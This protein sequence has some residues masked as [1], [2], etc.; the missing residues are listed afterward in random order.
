MWQ[1][2]I[3]FWVLAIFKLIPMGDV[4][5]MLGTYSQNI[6]VRMLPPSASLEI[7]SALICG[8]KL[9]G[10]NY[11]ILKTLNLIHVIMASG[12]VLFWL[13]RALK[14]FANIYRKLLLLG[15]YFFSG[16]HPSI[17]RCLI[18]QSLFKNSKSLSVS[19]SLLCSGIAAWLLMDH[20]YILILSWACAILF[21]WA[22]ML[23]QNLFIKALF[24]YIGF[25]PF[26][27][28]MGLTHPLSILAYLL[29]ATSLSAIFLP[30][31]LS[32]IVCPPLTSIFD[33]TWNYF[34]L[35]AQSI[36]PYLVTGKQNVFISISHLV[37][38]TALIQVGFYFFEM[39]KV[40]RLWRALV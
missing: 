25:L 38:Y 4:L 8:V 2:L 1:L 32:C 14:P 30:L 19:L 20:S 3:F 7:Q 18:H 35:L 31:S 6:C 40:R 23:S 17:L 12:A 11:E 10:Q 16:C 36:T 29:F 33:I 26:S 24:F 37:F 22:N 13:E 28:S 39:W 34:F 9:K 15:F 5:L 21:S 27:Y